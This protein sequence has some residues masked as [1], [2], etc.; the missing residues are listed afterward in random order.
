MLT[1]TRR[2]LHVAVCILMLMPLSTLK[3]F[4]RNPGSPNTDLPVHSTSK[5]FTD[6]SKQGYYPKMVTGYS[7]DN[8][9]HYAALWQKNGHFPPVSSGTV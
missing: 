3:V 4:F 9:A 1:M 8:A 2:L 6:L 7:Q 5:L